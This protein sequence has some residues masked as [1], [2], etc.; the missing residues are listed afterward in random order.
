MVEIWSAALPL[1]R[2]RV[3][4]RHFSAWIEPIRAQWV[5]GE[6]HLKVP[7]RFFQEWITQ[8]FSNAIRE[9]LKRVSPDAHAFRVVV[10]DEER[11]VPVAPQPEP[12]PAPAPPRRAK[13]GR[14]VDRYTFDNFVVGAANEVVFQAA[15]AV[16]AAPGRRFNPVFLHG[17]TG[18]GKTHLI[19]GLGHDLLC[20]RARMRIACLS[21]ESFMN[22]L[23]NA[24][25]QDQMNKFRERFRQVDAL[26]LDDVQFLAG[27]E[28]TQEEFFHTF[29]ALYAAQK[30]IVLTSDK[31]PSAIAGLEQRLRSRFEGGL[32][33]DIHPPTREM[34]LAILRA[35]AQ[36]QAAELPQEVADVLVD[37]TGPNVREL[38]GALN[39]VLAMSATGGRPI[40]LALAEAAVGPLRRARPAVSVEAVQEAVSTGFGVA[41]SDLI[42]HRR[43]RQLALPRQ[44]AMYLSRRVAEASFPTIGEKF[45]GRDHSTVMYAFRTMEVRRSTDDE[46]ERMLARLEG[47]LREAAR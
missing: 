28:R 7:S 37:R 25:R 24:L 34:R 41:V 46:V 42:S 2:E 18:L 31:S 32:T 9:V 15:K 47:Q 20:N 10:A 39:R 30:Q 27:K 6:L 23:I 11:S 13:I 17:A 45:G 3:G 40:T 21:A 44:I 5:D 36:A 35:K 1:L 29:N 33:A 12:P 22:T 16:S 19:N 43:S 38:E 4:E 26:I 8:H 14:L